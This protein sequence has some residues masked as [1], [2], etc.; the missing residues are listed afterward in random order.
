MS[1]DLLSR[2]N[3]LN[4]NAD[5]LSDRI[6]EL[7]K[8][9]ARSKLI[10]K[11]TGKHVIRILPYLHQKNNDPI[12]QIF[13]HYELENSNSHVVCPE[14]TFGHRGEC[15]IC[16]LVDGLYKKNTEESKEI[17]G[18]IRAKARY[19]VPI[20]VR[21]EEEEG[22]K[23]WAFGKDVRDDIGSYV[24]DKSEYP[25]IFHPIKGF[26]WTLDYVAPKKDDKG[27]LLDF[28]QRAIK[29]RRKESPVLEFPDQDDPKFKQKAEKISE[30]I[31]ELIDSIPNI[32]ESE[33]KPKTTEELTELLRNQIGYS[34][35]PQPKFEDE[36][37]EDESRYV[38]DD[39]AEDEDLQEEEKPK[40]P[41]D[42]TSKKKKDED[43]DE[44][45]DDESEDALLNMFRKFEKD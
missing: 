34:A 33:F 43:E 7:M 27:R 38:D 23:F 37:Q 8:K 21:G 25:D 6:N 28:G 26:D 44:D 22:V 19:Y 9:G 35:A 3:A 31:I 10:W 42:K 1:Q 41:L 5:E 32:F 12:I 15:P 17:A 16:Q 29:P 24:Q 13:F 39:D 2:L 14:R 18:K 20:I 11:P 40:M 45:D 36:P 4:P 30:K